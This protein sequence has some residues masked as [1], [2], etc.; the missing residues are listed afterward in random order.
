M[1]SKDKGFTFSSGRLQLE[2]DRHTQSI[3]NRDA[4]V[5]RE[6]DPKMAH[7][8]NNTQKVHLAV[9]LLGIYQYFVFDAM[10]SNPT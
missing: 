8:Y 9:C 1:W 6:N 7:S 5:R 10:H 2:A 4:Q 3:K